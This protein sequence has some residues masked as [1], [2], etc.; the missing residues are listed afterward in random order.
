MGRSGSG[1]A[2]V[3]QRLALELAWSRSRDRDCLRIDGWSDRELHQLRQLSAPALARRVAVLPSELDEAASVAGAGGVGFQPVAG[4][5]AVDRNGLCFTPRFPFVDGVSYT[6]R[7]G[8]WTASIARSRRERAA[9]TRVLAIYPTAGELPLNQLKLYIVFSSAMSEGWA[10]RAVSLRRAD[11]DQ[12]LEGA[13]LAME[14]E[15]WDRGE[16]G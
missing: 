16:R 13:L 1:A 3:R 9:S 12:P 4:E 2:R 14:P 7:V 11:R 15:L 5:F 8:E 10:G 6:V